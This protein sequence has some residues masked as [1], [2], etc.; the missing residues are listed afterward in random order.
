M[1]K[2]LAEYAEKLKGK[3]PKQLV[4]I[5]KQTKDEDRKHL[6]FRELLGRSE[7]VNVVETLR[8]GEV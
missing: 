4:A 6:V 7:V 5:Y 1:K 8:G 3:T 2:A